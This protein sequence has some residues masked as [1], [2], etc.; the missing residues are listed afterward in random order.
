[1]PIKDWSLYPKNW[2]NELVPRILHRDGYR[3][4]ECGKLSGLSV[5][6]TCFDPGCDDESHMLTLDRRCHLKADRYHHSVNASETAKQKR[7]ARERYGRSTV[8]DPLF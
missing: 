4:R 6:H 1:M 3:C 8:Y 7:E 2:K 5:H